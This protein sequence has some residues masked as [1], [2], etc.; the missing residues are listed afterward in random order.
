MVE[1][2][3]GKYFIPFNNVGRQHPLGPM[4]AWLDDN[5][6]KGSN[7]YMIH[8]VMPRPNENEMI[9]HPPHIHK[10][11]E[12]LIH[13]GTDPEHPE[14]LGGDCEIFLGPEQERHVFNKTCVIYIPP[15]FIHA[16]WK[17]MNTRRPWIFV[18]VNQGPRHTE[19]L[20]P[21]VLSKEVRDKIDW[22]RWKEEGF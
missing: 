17:P 15:L 2:K 4:I 11:G 7:F 16:P 19:K 13:L 8:W 12:L 6:V 5:N 18:E 14:D 9:G 21:Q 20:Y 1:T 10:D 22:K 3:Y